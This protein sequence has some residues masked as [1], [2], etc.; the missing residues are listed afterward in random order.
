MS[1][2]PISV[3]YIPLVDAAPLIIAREIGFA[4]EEGLALTL[5]AAPSWS[6]LRDQLMLGRLEAAHMLFP[7][8]I[9]AALGLGG[10]NTRIDILQILSHNGNSIGV[11]RALAD[12]MRAQG[13]GFDFAD[14]R[15]A[16]EALIAGAAG[17]LRI[18]VPFPFSMHAELLYHWLGAIGLSAP[19]DLDVHTVP[20]PLMAEALAADEIDV[21]CVGAPWGS[22]AVENRVG[23]MLLPGT[24]IRAN[25]PEKV[26]AV[27]HDW[28]EAE[29]GLTRRLMRAVWQAGRWLGHERNLLTAAELLARRDYLDLPPELIERTLTGNLVISPRG[30]MRSVPGYMSFQTGAAGYP[31]A[32]QGA[33]VAARLATRLG[34]SREEAMASAR[35]ICRTDLYTRNL[36]DLG[37]DL[38]EARDKIEGAL[39]APGAIPAVQ[40]QVILPS[41]AFFDGWIFDPFANS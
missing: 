13:Y 34:L 5:N 10:F 28:A 31:W 23:E 8:P 21:F 7:M 11:S 12:R 33:L 3:G 19:Q 6:T 18:G 26:L 20:P 17:R 40:G 36:A 35:A 24:A 16:G 29:P 38:P 32:S 15:A 41:D 1:G 14:A 25:A 22:I 30:E 2:V 37:A 39:N 27:R 9:A 4:E